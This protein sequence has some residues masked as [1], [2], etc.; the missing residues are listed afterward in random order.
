M[1]RLI[2]S[3]KSY[4]VQPNTEHP[5]HPNLQDII[6]SYREKQKKNTF[7]IGSLQPEKFTENDVKIFTEKELKTYQAFFNDSENLKKIDRDDMSRH[8]KTSEDKEKKL[9]NNEERKNPFVENLKKKIF[10]FKGDFRWIN[11]FIFLF[12]SI[13]P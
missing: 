12:F 13:I 9:K 7:S 8:K 10:P 11:K 1:S 3:N 2:Q 5:D 6:S 4:F